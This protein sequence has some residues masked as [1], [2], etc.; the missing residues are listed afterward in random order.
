[1]SR[2]GMACSM[3]SPAPPWLN[4]VKSKQ[5]VFDGI[6]HHVVWVDENGAA[7]LYVDGVVDATDF[8]YYR[9]NLVLNTTCR[10]RALPRLG[11]PLFLWIGG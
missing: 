11:R 8:T 5:V 9:S 3:S 7:R 4:D 1:M 6:W 10:G 2:G